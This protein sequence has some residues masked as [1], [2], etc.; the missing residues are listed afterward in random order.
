MKKFDLNIYTPYGHYLSDKVDYLSVS[1]ENF[2]L[3]ILADHA[4]LISTITICEIEIGEGE[5]RQYYAT[6]GGVIKVKNNKVDLILESIESADEIDIER[7]EA[8]KERA[9]NRLAQGDLEP[10]MVTRN[11]IA[12]A[13]AINRINI[14]KKK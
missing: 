6:S 11:R 9:E 2:K 12:L 7:A 4:E 3:G 13:R 1:S 10:L 8:A 5:E 14:Y